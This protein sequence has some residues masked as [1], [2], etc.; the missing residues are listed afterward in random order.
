M[1]IL[2]SLETVRA[3]SPRSAA[4]AAAFD[5]FDDL[6][7]AERV[8]Q[9]QGTLRAIGQDGRVGDVEEGLAQQ[10]QRR[11]VAAPRGA[12][13]RGLRAGRRRRARAPRPRAAARGVER[14]QRARRPAAHA[15]AWLEV[16]PSRLAAES[17]AQHRP[18]R[19]HNLAQVVV[20]AKVVLV[21]EK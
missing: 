12:A 19:Q 7:G 6:P 9:L 8:R 5:R 1:A 10:R 11:G 3:Q 2:G 13:A 17:V 4:F 21:T 16:D 20:V 18:E 14:R 15:A